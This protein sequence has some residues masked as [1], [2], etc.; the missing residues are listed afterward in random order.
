MNARPASE[1]ARD[2]LIAL[3]TQKKIPTPDNYA[4][5]FHQIAGT[6]PR[7]NLA[8]ELLQAFSKDPSLGQASLDGAKAAILA[9]DWPKLAGILRPAKTPQPRAPGSSASADLHEQIARLI[10]FS[11]PAFGTDDNRIGPDALALVDFCRSSARDEGLAALKERLSIFNHR[12]SFIA[13]DQA[14]IKKTLLGMLRLVFENISELSDDDRWLS[15]QAALLA[16]A[17]QEP[18]SRRRLDDLEAR[19]RDLIFKQAEIKERQAQAQEKIR[20][21]T[22]QFIENVSTMAESTGR[23]HERMS[24]LATKIE[25]AHS[26][27]AIAPIIAEALDATR[28]LSL[29]ALRA[30]DAMAEMKLAAEASQAE[31]ARL[32]DELARASDAARH[33]PLTG[34]LNR[35]GLEEAMDREASRFSRDGASLCLALLDVDNFKQLNDVHGH[36]VGDQAL[37]HLASIVKGALRPQ[38]VLSRFGGEEFVVLMPNTTLA[39]AEIAMTRLQRELTKSLFMGNEERILITFSAGVSQIKKGEPPSSAL[40]R[41]DEAMYVA[42]K[43]GKNKVVLASD[44]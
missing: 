5:I 21:L 25:R 35:K 28:A 37:T 11:L 20:S 26:L 18:L 43:T 40:K 30:R 12:L 4:A 22:S 2:S 31:V 9:G 14:K 27:D 34:A 16:A 19:L 7:E 39:D 8:T 3:A 17:S 32:T 6:E 44:E 41:A 15:G 36:H 29:D 10:E 23:H 24:K 33:D 1:I 42:K 38:D 13:E